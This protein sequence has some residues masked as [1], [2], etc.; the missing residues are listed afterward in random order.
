MWWGGLLLGCRDKVFPNKGLYPLC[1][2]SFYDCSASTVVYLSPR[3]PTF[4]T[5]G[6][7]MLRMK[8]EEENKKH[9]HLNENKARAM[10]NA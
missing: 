9:K 10:P 5:E 7:R 3:K 1:L 2:F 6:T 8:I 4:R